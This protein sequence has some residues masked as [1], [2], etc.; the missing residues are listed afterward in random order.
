MNFDTG[1][2]RSCATRTCS[3]HL[4]SSTGVKTNATTTPAAAPQIMLSAMVPAML[5]ICCATRRLAAPNAVNTTAFST[6]EPSSG[7]ARPYFTA[8]RVRLGACNRGA[9]C[10]P[11]RTLSCRARP[12]H[13]GGSRSCLCTLQLILSPASVAALSQCRRDTLQSYTQ[14]QPP[15]AG[16][17]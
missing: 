14:S 15:A 4:M 12:S 2:H 10:L 16:H 8:L 11:C 3:R 7:L 6:M 5:G 13:C 17:A 1:Q 9:G